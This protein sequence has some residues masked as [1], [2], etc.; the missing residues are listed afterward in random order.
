MIGN[1]PTGTLAGTVMA[2]RGNLS[3]RLFLRTWQQLFYAHHNFQNCLGTTK[4]S[5][6]Y[7]HHD[8][9]TKHSNITTFE[10][11]RLLILKP[12]SLFISQH[13]VPSTTFNIRIQHSDLHH[14]AFGRFSTC[15]NH[16]YEAACARQDNELDTGKNGVFG[17][18]RRKE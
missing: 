8:Q 15:E 7:K 11:N 6:H 5:I 4:V 9:P 18:P 17:D 13:S 2:S 12:W 10:P 16:R 1:M 14:V 3:R